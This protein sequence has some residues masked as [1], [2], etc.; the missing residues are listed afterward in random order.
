MCN[1]PVNIEKQP[2]YHSYLLRLWQE[3]KQSRSWRMSL[4]N[5]H[6]GE[7]RGF[8]SLEALFD[9]LCQLMEVPSQMN[10]GQVRGKE[11]DS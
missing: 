6:T 7:R 8:A 9:F 5:A 3:D 1:T 10:I 2:A 4:E 11:V